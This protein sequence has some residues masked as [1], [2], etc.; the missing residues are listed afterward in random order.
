MGK[1]N[2][3]E[4]EVRSLDFDNFLK[5]RKYRLVVYRRKNKMGDGRKSLF[6]GTTEA[7]G[8]RY[9]FFCILTNDRKKTEEEIIAFYNKR[10]K[11]E[12]V[13]DQ[14]NNDFN[15]KHLPSSLLK[16]NVV[17]MI[18]TAVLRNF[19]VYFVRNAARVTGGLIKSASRIKSFI[20]NFLT[21]P[22]TLKVTRAG[23]RILTLHNPTP[24]L[25]AY[26]KRRPWTR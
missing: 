24:T 7:I 21:C 1:N 15:W 8:D 13:F 3:E 17:F 18:L 14:M 12:R 9:K 5:E 10:G 20:F 22:A 6:D 11:I 19:Y 4:M 16:N 2:E 25:E 23:R 26:V